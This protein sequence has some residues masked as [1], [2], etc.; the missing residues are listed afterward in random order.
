MVIV[1][2]ASITHIYWTMEYGGSTA[3]SMSHRYPRKKYFSMPLVMDH[4]QLSESFTAVRS[5][6]ILVLP[7][8]STT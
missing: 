6:R 8:V 2:M 1:L 5:S 4:I 7:Y 3:I